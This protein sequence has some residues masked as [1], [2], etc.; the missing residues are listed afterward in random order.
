MDRTRIT[1][2]TST[3]LPLRGGLTSDAPWPKA[4]R[5]GTFRGPL[6]WVL[7]GSGWTV[8]RQAVDFALLCAAV[9]VAQGG[10][11]SALHPPAARAPLLV[12]PPL[13]MLFFNLSGVYRT[14]L[15]A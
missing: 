4:L 9:V 15:R 13:V 8:L 2:Q 12:L 11:H 3:T 5:A 14:R 1:Q 10:V 7:E 6:Q